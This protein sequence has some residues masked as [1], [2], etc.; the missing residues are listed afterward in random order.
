MPKA[1]LLEGSEVKLFA[2]NELP[3]LQSLLTIDALEML[4]KYLEQG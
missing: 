4:E 2:L 1:D 3:E